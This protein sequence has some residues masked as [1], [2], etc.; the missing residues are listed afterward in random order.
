MLRDQT[1]HHT[2]LTLQD[3]SG[4][5]TLAYPRLTVTKDVQC[6]HA[7]M[8]S[9]AVGG[10][11]SSEVG[12]SILLRLKQMN[13]SSSVTHLITYSDSCGGQNHNVNTVSLW[14]HSV[15][16]D[17]LPITTVDQKFNV[18][19]HSFLPNAVPLS[20]QRRDIERSTCTCKF[21]MVGT[22]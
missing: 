10:R 15:A 2:Q 6:M 5:T 19:R 21:L 14:L 3:N 9:E 18:S 8:W 12:S 11:G 1:R 7:C 17:Y 13:L 22:S 16:C 4:R 20:L